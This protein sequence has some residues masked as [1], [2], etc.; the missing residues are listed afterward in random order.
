[1]LCDLRFP[2]ET[3]VSYLFWN[4]FHA[5]DVEARKR[6][7][8]NS[9]SPSSPGQSWDVISQPA[10]EFG[11]T[12]R[13]LTDILQ[14]AD[15]ALKNMLVAFEHIAH[16]VEN[17]T[18]I[19][20]VQ[21][22]AYESVDSV[23]ALFRLLAPHFK[24]VDCSLL[25]ALVEAAG[26]KQ[27]IQRLD[28]YLHMSNSCLLGNG[29]EKVLTLQEIETCNP[30]QPPP[31]TQDDSKAL[32][33]HDSTNDII[34]SQPVAYS[35]S[36]PVTTVV[37]GEEMSWGTFRCIQSLICG[38]FTVPQCALPYDDKKPGSV[39]ITCITSLEMFSQIKS[40]LLDDGDML[41]L[42]REKIVSIQV[43]KDYTIAVGNHDYWM[44]SN[45]PKI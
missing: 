40:T 15:G 2:I 18:Y 7:A 26:V 10:I 31:Q 33:P 23:R 19:S 37:E 30:P 20:I 22:K 14:S 41:L 9:S 17:E 43:G 13:D 11:K 28:E 6:T 42:L 45:T 29:S 44:V 27:A 34:T 12:M 16:Y 35:T 1:M 21:S 3:T 38:M 5:I 36:V 32:V 39:V 24:P 25:K 4:M 8:T